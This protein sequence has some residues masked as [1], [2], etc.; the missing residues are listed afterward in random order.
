MRLVYRYR[1]I[2]CVQVM[3]V[4]NILKLKKSLNQKRVGAEFKLILSHQQRYVEKP[5]LSLL[6]QYHWVSKQ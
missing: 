2:T 6:S 4:L 5:D 3:M 1:Y